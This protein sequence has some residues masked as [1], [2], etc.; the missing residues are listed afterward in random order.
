[1]TKTKQGSRIARMSSLAATL[2]AL[3][4][5]LLAATPGLAQTPPCTVEAAQAAAPPGVKIGPINDLNPRL[6]PVPS[7]ALLVPASG[8]TPAYCLV[9]GSVMT[10]PSTGKTANFGL[11]LPLNW[12]NKFMFSGCGGLCGVVFQTTPDDARGGG[13]PPDALAKGYAIAATDDG[14]ASA[15]VGFVFDGSWAI[16]APGVADED[17]VTDFFYRAVHA[18]TTAGKQFVQKWYAGALAR[19][20]YV[21]CSDGGRE[22]MVEVTR[23][24]DDF[25]GYIAGDPF[26]DVPGEILAGRTSRA[27]LDAPDSYI[28]PALLTLI[29]KAVYA[30][31]DAA[32]GVKDNLIQNPGKCSFDPQ[33]LL[34]KN[35]QIADCLTQDQV[36]TLSAWISAAKDEQGR[37]VSYGFAV[38]D[39]YNS[40][41][42]GNSV[43]AWAEATGAPQD[44]N[45]TEP[46][47][48]M[49]FKQPPAWMF[50][51]QCFKYLVYLDPN[52]DNNHKSAVDR[53]G[54][55]G[56]AAMTQLEA[57]TQAGRADDPTKL[58]PFITSG[59]K[60][61]LYHG[62]SDGFITPFRTVRFYQNWARLAGGYDVLKKNARL[63]MVPGMYHCAKGP[64]P[65]FFDALG[66]LER[67]VEKGVAPEGIVATKYTDDDPTQAAL[68]TMPLCSF[69]Q[70][71]HYTGSGDVNNAANWA[72]TANQDLLQIGPSGARAGLTTP[73][74]P[75]RPPG[76]RRGPTRRTRNQNAPR[77]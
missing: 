11:A 44:I 12:N 55:V 53:Q 51:D 67:W 68:R 2:G 56:N 8:S 72:C 6:P 60:L 22:G 75:Q 57:R 25:D 74:R 66:A 46:W 48:A 10:N 54:V 9:T 28:P 15:P 49:V 64:G 65:N 38:S 61:I 30:N 4:F 32:D 41:A 63:F 20:Y 70:Q 58:G 73:E 13:Y 37:V 31:C 5:G 62:Y 18:V 14:H 71:A 26:F 27:L 21:G 47:G 33:S 35:G 52:F 59:R 7:G 16:K 45:A 34:C 24:P 42:P 77:R 39:I 3:T 23:Y 1:M 36:N 76:G 19:S 50:Y 69:P 40:S 17:A 29:D 43:F